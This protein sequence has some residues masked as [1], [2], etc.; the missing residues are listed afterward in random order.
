MDYNS[1]SGSSVPGISQ[2][3]ILECVAT[4][5]SRGFSQFKHRT[6]VSCVGRHG[7]FSTEPPG[8]PKIDVELVV[9]ASLP[10]ELPGKPKMLLHKLYNK[11]CTDLKASL[12]DQMLKN[13]SAM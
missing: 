2:V 11:Q 6:H 7:F 10:D 13:L 4:S 12:V 9:F 1:P 3:R 5:F 8:N